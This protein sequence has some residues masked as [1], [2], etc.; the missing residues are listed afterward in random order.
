MTQL[1]PSESHSLLLVYRL[2][3][4]DSTVFV[5]HRTSHRD[6]SGLQSTLYF[7]INLLSRKPSSD[8]VTHTS[9]LFN[10]FPGIGQQLRNVAEHQNQTGSL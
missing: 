8:L 9:K 3:N 7:A 5:S 6:F 2:P 10:E 4:S 1:A